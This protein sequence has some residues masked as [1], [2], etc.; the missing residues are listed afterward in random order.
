[1]KFVA[2]GADGFRLHPIHS[3]ALQ[4]VPHYP[5]R[6]MLF[7]HNQLRI[8]LLTRSTSEYSGWVTNGNEDVCTLTL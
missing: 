1:M 8:P 7:P 4:S 2:I 3:V 5:D 6:S